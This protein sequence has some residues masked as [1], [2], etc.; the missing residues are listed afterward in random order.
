[1]RSDPN[2]RR[3]ITPADFAA[4]G[5]SGFHSNFKLIYP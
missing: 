5:G 2:V 4:R 1:M 3:I